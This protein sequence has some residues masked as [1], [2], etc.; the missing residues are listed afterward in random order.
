[1]L[2]HRA[3]PPRSNPQAKKS[4]ERIVDHLAVHLAP[5][6]AAPPPSSRGRR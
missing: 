5:G 3:L 6:Y 2:G 1:V 4:L